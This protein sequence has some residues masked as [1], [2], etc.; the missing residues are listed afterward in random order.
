M[1]LISISNIFKLSNLSYIFRVAIDLILV[2]FLIFFILRS[3][4]KNQRTLQVFKGIIIIVIVKGFTSLFG[5]TTLNA[6]V[7]L[8]LSWGILAI[9]IIFQPEIRAGLEKLGAT[10]NQV[11]HKLSNDQK[12]RIMDELVSAISRMSR[13]H[14]GAL[15]TF[16]RQQDLSE[17]IKTGVR[18]KAD[19]KA[20]LITTIFYEGTPLHDGATIIKN[21]KIVSS[22]CFY[23][24][25]RKEVPQQFGARHR[26]AIGISE[27]NDSLTVVVSEETGNIS[28]AQN[29]EIK[30]I[31]PKEL[32][33]Q[34]INELDWYRSEDESHEQ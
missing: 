27:L 3:L 28:F 1:T 15:I 4:R 19:I 22:A 6:L 21:D 32:R 13:D 12:E 20:E 2:F 34:L 17:Y 24:P 26:A 7:D 31:N 11:K 9:I 14:T 25:T 8:I 5:L 33:A 23:P 18:F 16:E 30:K 10:K 29:G